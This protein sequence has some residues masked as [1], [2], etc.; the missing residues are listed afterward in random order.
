MNP[1]DDLEAL[2][3]QYDTV[4]QAT[5]D[6]R[7]PEVERTIILRPHSPWYTDALREAKQEK[8]RRERKWSKTGLV[9]HKEYY[10]DQC[11]IYRDLLN[12][13][14]FNYHCQ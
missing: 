4:L 6:R 14:K 8:H 7:A 2:V 12:I 1:A 13:A 9:V 11:V 10:N 5:L 3:R